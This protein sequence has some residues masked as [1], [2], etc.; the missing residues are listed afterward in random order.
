MSDWPTHLP[1]LKDAKLRSH[2]D[3]SPSIELV[4]EGQG[5]ERKI[6][7]E[8]RTVQCI[9]ALKSPPRIEVWWGQGAGTYTLD[10]ASN[11]LMMGYAPFKWRAKHIKKTWTLW[12]DALKVKKGEK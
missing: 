5:W 12:F 1:P 4:C 10:L 8:E 9:R 6:K 3:L 11:K 2:A 7:L